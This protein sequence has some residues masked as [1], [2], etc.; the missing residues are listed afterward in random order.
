VTTPPEIVG[1]Y[2]ALD[3]YDGPLLEI[4]R[5]DFADGDRLVQVCSLCTVH[6]EEKPPSDRL[7]AVVSGEDPWARAVIR[8]SRADLL[9][10]LDLVDGK[11]ITDAHGRQGSGSVPIPISTREE[12]ALGDPRGPIAPYLAGTELSAEAHDEWLARV[13]EQPSDD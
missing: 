6:P 10:M 8:L 13:C 12:V 3:W 11:P 9:K 2:I 7:R 4:A 5:V 1:E